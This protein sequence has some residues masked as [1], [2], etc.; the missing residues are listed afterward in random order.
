MDL[1]D[2]AAYALLERIARK[3]AEPFDI[4]VNEK[5]VGQWRSE[6]REM[7]CEAMNF[8]AARA[9]FGP[10]GEKQEAS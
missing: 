5:T 8:V 9:K 1:S 10:G 4:D 7:L 2:A 3:T 6:I